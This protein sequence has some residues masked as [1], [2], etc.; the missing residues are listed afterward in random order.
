[1]PATILPVIL[2]GGGGKR[3]APLSTPECPK[4]FVEMFGTPPNSLFQRTLKRL[5][6]GDNILPPLIVGNVQNSDLIKHAI[7]N[8]SKASLLLETACRNTGPSVAIA[9]LWAAHYSPDAILAIMPS[10]HVVLDND[11]FHA[12]IQ[13]AC[14]LA[15][16]G[17]LVTF[18]IK[19]LRPDTAYG[20]IALGD[21]LTDIAPGASKIRTFLEKPD[22]ETARRYLKDGDY[23]WNSGIFVCK[24]AVILQQFRL[25]AR[26]L[27]DIAERVLNKSTQFER[28]STRIG[29]EIVLDIEESTV[30]PSISLDH[31]LMEKTKVAAMVPFSSQWW[32]LG[33]NDTLAAFSNAFPSGSHELS[34]RVVKH[35]KN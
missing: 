35:L 6:S 25:L 16:H 23:F 33:S 31:A 26:D 32:D 15:A 21:G 9:S 3:L 30:F 4:Q 14:I 18:G 17:Y 1:M 13:T 28:Q 8:N 2:C 7:G 20:Y 27:L 22:A 12:D 34:D 29:S 11:A 10:D 19:P 5:P 24:P